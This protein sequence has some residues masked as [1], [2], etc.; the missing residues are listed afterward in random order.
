MI[1][2]FVSVNVAD[3][4]ETWSQNRKWRGRSALVSFFNAGMADTSSEAYLKKEPP[5]AGYVYPAVYEFT[6]HL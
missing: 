1:P 6:F 3:T 2:A 4:D 5:S